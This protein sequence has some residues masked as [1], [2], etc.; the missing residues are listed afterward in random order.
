MNKALVSIIIPTFNRSELL[1]ETLESVRKQSYKDWECIIIDDGSVDN[2]KEV[3]NNL[4]N[5]D[6]RFK[7]FVK[8]IDFCKGASSSRNFGFELSKGKY[9]QWLDDDDLISENKIELQVI[10]LE[11]INNP[12]AITCC[13]WDFLWDKKKYV[14]KNILKNKVSLDCENFFIQLRAQLTFVP[15]HAYLMPRKIILKSGIWNVNLSLNDDAEFLTRVLLVSN[16]LVNTAD[17]HVLYRE[18]HIKRVSR[19][20]SITGLNSILLSLE[21]IS[22]HLKF[23][24]IKCVSY[25]K[26]KLFNVFYMHWKNHS[27]VLEKHYYFFKENG[28][29]L[30]Y[31]F[32]YKL[33]YAIYKLVLPWYKRNFKNKTN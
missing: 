20:V 2:T 7:L 26:W 12:N 6:S 22:A 16:Y 11:R 19:D 17:C 21:L 27:K 30:N 32:F 13:D 29:D 15:I 23:K 28:I 31:A 24:N 5:E 10:K 33:K 4:M 9:I 8:P 25:F 14:K 3:V 18:H 1:L